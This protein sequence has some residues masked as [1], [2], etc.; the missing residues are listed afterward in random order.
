MKKFF[1]VLLIAF[2]LLL[3]FTPKIKDQ[4]IQNTIN[5]TVDIVSAGDSQ[6][7]N[8]H[9]DIQGHQQCKSP[10]RLCHHEKGPED[11]AR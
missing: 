8:E 10:G 4:V 2:G 11:G 5:N 1:A 7:Q 3:I 6:R 9:P